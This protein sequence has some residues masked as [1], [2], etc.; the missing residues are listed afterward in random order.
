MKSPWSFPRRAVVA[1]VAVVAGVLGAATAAA[2]T[3]PPLFAPSSARGSALLAAGPRQT[4]ARLVTVRADLLAVAMDSGAPGAPFL[5]NLFDDVALTLRRVRVDHAT[6]NHRTWVGTSGDRDEVVAALT[7]GPE[8]LTG[9][10]AARG[11]SYAI[12]TAGAGDALVRELPVFDA[13][14]ELPARLAPP[15]A[16]DQTPRVGALAADGPARIDVLV[17]YTPAA[18]VRAGSVAAI[19]ASL[20]NAV[21]VTNTAFQ[22]SGIAASL[23]TAALR[24]LAYVEAP[25]G[26]TDDLFAMA[27]GGS[28]QATVEAMRAAAGADLV[29]LVTGRATASAGCGVA[30]LGPSPTA[31]FSVTEEACLFAGQW[32]FSHEIGHNFGADH[33]PGDPV[34]S[35]VPYARGYRDSNVRTLMAYAASGTP[36]R[37]LNF[38]SSTVREPAVTGGPTGNSLQDNARRLAETAATVAAF[39]SGGPAPET[40]GALTASVLGGTVTLTWT[41]PATGGTVSGYRLDAGPAPG[42]AS[43]GPFFTTATGVVFPNVVPGRYYARVRSVGPG[44]E[45]APGPDVTVDVTTACAVPG[46]ATITATVSSG[47]AAL[48]WFAPPGNG[49]TTYEIG[50][51]SAPG[52]L[53]LGVFAVGTLTAA[54]VPAPPGR[55]VVRVRGV[56]ACGPGA[57]S[58]ELLV[59]VP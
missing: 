34:V 41:P 58:A 25:G 59:V 47:I 40:P 55:Y 21:A 35:A 56:N 50:I 51:G 5:L 43:Y 2:Q 53:D 31:I 23:A 46:P 29:A 33:A 32:S 17:L 14:P 52:R 27:A 10:V 45:S 9:Q 28:L 15:P 42:V 48:Q 30:F 39:A 12:E 49:V 20:A 37:S 44:G 18:R 4:R 36:A 54:S 13:P 24:E 38:S 22:R 3:P 26:I 57:P 1:F 16:R 6:R 19:D 11:V 7:L 8:G